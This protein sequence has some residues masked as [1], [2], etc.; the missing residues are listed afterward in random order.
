MVWIRSSAVRTLGVTPQNRSSGQKHE[1]NRSCC[2]SP[3]DVNLVFLRRAH[4]ECDLP[5]QCQVWVTEHVPNQIRLCA[6]WYRML[7]AWRPIGLSPGLEARRLGPLRWVARHRGLA[8]IPIYHAP[9]PA[10]RACDGATRPF[11]GSTSLTIVEAVAKTYRTG[12]HL[13]CPTKSRCGNRKRGNLA[14][15]FEQTRHRTYR[16]NPSLACPSVDE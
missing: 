8:G 15:T 14:A 16:S 9:R 11:R 7:R 6:R 5:L 3:V 12:S 4:A 2:V 13:G 1:Q 10:S